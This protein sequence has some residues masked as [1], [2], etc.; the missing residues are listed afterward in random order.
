MKGFF[1]II[2]SLLVCYTALASNVETHVEAESSESNDSRGVMLVPRIISRRK[3]DPED[4]P[5]G[6][7]TLYNPLDSNQS[8]S[9]DD[10]DFYPRTPFHKLYPRHRVGE[11]VDAL[12][13]EETAVEELAALVEFGCDIFDN[14]KKAVVQ[15]VKTGVRGAGKAATAYAVH[16]IFGYSLTDE[17]ETKIN[18]ILQNPSWIPIAIDQ[19][20][21]ACSSAKKSSPIT[22]SAS[23]S[24]M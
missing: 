3:H 14:L 16:K 24:N 10:D 19:L 18:E 17:D 6:Q 12:G 5:E 2:G 7:R 23:D 9:D 20:H 8:D 11:S 4:S 21:Q 13:S 22:V 1:L 15:G